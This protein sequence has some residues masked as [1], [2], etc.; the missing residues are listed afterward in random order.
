MKFYK[1][2]FVSLLIVL[3]AYSTFAV[4]SLKSADTLLEE[5]I[6]KGGYQG[7]YPSGFFLY[8]SVEISDTTLILSLTYSGH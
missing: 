1:F 5:K 2:I 4:V 7:S 8:K 6:M 3:F